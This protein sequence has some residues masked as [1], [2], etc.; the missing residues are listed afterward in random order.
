VRSTSSSV[1]SR[2][3]IVD[4]ALQLVSEG[5]YDALQVRAI[6]ERAGVSSRTMY[7]H[8]PSLDSLLIVAVAEQSDGLYRPY[9]TAPPPG[10]TPAVR[11]NDLIG[12]LTESMTAHRALTIALLR[13]LISGKP[14]V[15]QHVEGFRTMLQVR[16][17]AAIT[18]ERPD[19]SDPEVVEILAS[20]WFAALAGWAS[21]VDRDAHIGEIM[22][23][24]TARLLP[25]GPA[26]SPAKARFHPHGIRVWEGRLSRRGAAEPPG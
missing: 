1:A 18:P 8:F 21:G 14:D 20:I 25:A 5:G 17:A 3:R 7:Q 15:E 11:I 2:R 13:A 23:A 24:S 22:R 6:A 19:Q 12:E 4:A 16:L 9:P 10:S 26:P